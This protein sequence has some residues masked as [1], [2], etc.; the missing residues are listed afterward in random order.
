MRKY[1]VIGFLLIGI[2]GLIGVILYPTF[3]DNG[4]NLQLI[5]AN[6]TKKILTHEEAYQQQVKKM[7]QLKEKESTLFNL[8]Q[9]ED[10]IGLCSSITD[11]SLATECK[12]QFTIRKA[13]SSYNPATCE[14]LTGST[15]I[16][17]CE[18][19]V[20]YKLSLSAGDKK[21]CERVVDATRKN[22]CLEEVSQILFHSM[23]ASGE[24]TESSCDT[25]VGSANDACIR[26]FQ[27]EKDG[28]IY[29]L[30]TK[31]EDISLCKNIIDTEVNAL[32]QDTIRLKLALTEGN[33]S[34]CAS[35]NDSKKKALC[36]KQLERTTMIG[37]Y[38][39]VL[40]SHDIELCVKITDEK[41]S[42]QCHDTL[43]LEKIHAT[44][45]NTL[46]TNLFATGSI[47][48]C[49]AMFPVQTPLSDTGTTEEIVPPQ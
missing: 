2:T 34:I 26:E 11:S 38:K 19:E 12:N 41:L 49:Q 7:E 28:H 36:Q 8:A 43:L 3:G 9:K 20:F 45:D 25:L 23:T 29:E 30:A 42:H 31:T 18:D 44:S 47:S 14:T 10:N 24:L 27:K 17:K 48:A 16:Q 21:S 33:N 46:C 6:A 15:I 13:V 5:R 39:V 40:A 35:I 1:F 4:E 37:L 32:C 22:T